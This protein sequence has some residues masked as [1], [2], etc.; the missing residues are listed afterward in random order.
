LFK[1]GFPRGKGR[2]SLVKYKPSVEQTD[3]DYPFILTTGR[4]LFQYHT[5]SMTRRVKPINAVSP[6]AYIEINPADAKRLAIENG[7]KVKV[8]SRRGS[9]MVKARVSKWPA[10]GVVFIPFHFKEAAANALT[11]ST[12]LDPLSKIP[13]F[14]VSA[15][16]IEKA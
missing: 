4:Q 3:K 15:V 13:S 11:S 12:S 16:K 8:S 6:E 5:G 2:F 10:A 14:K 7:E 1:G 9:I